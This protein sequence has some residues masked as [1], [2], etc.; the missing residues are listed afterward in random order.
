[1]SKQVTLTLPV[2][3]KIYQRAE[4]RAQIEARPIT[5]VL[6]ENIQW[7][8]SPFHINEER[9]AMQH[10]VTIYE[11]MHSQ[12]WQQYAN[13]YIAMRNGQVIDHDDDKIALAVRIEEKYADQVVLIR[14]VQAELPKP[15]IV[16][17]PRFVTDDV[18]NK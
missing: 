13:K 11:S 18:R 3:D 1:M 8:F 14:Q 9:A 16:R 5:E 15:L 12:L 17:S 6:R 7:V 10:E 2:P 4:R